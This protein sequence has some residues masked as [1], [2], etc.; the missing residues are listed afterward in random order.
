[1]PNLYAI[2]SLDEIPLGVEYRVLA[3][4]LN[5]PDQPTYIETRD[6][7]DGLVWAIRAGIRAGFNALILELQEKFVLRGNCQR[8]MDFNAKEREEDR[9]NIQNHEER[10]NSAG[11]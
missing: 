1:M 6:P 2:H 11:V 7:V 8:D 5:Q 4:R 9:K 3:D 10:L